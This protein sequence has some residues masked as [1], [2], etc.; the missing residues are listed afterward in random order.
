[1]PE[2][3]DPVTTLVRLLKTNVR[4]VNDDGSLANIYCSREWYDRELLKNYDGQVTAGLRQPSQVKPLNLTQSLFQRILNL[5]VDCWLVDKTGKQPAVKSRAKLREEILRIV[6]QKRLNPNETVYDFCGLGTPGPHHAYHNANINEPNPSWQGWTELT[7]IE[8][9]KLWY[10]DNQRFVKS[11]TQSL[12]HAIALFKFKLETS[13]YDP[14]ENNVK[15]IILSFEGYGWAPGGDGVTIKVW[16][17]VTGSW[18]NAQ[19]GTGSS[20]E[21]ITI[22]LTANLTNYI[23]MDSSGV[24]YIYLVARTTYTSDGMFPAELYCDYVKC[25]LTV[26]GLAHIKFGAFNDADDVSV[27]PF[28]WHTEFQ[29]IGWMFENVPA[30]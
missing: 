13:K 14:H 30:T 18:E 11:T 21:T 27:K 28:L 12:C 23:E 24:G 6:R 25:I 5:K 2:V 19:S 9:Q 29:V 4:V 15:K 8:Y 1:V 20:D 3:E 7:D 22:T 10:S 16:N 26:E 17:H